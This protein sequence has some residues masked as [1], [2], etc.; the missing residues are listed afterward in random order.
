MSVH[1]GQPV[2][3]FGASLK[4]AEG[5]VVML[6]GRGGSAED[7]LSLASAMYRP[8][9]AYLAPQA[10]GNTW[11]PY[12]FLAPREENEPWLSSALAA[13]ASTVRMALDAGIG[14]EKIV[15]CGFS[16]GACLSAEF[17]A[18]EP[19]RYGGLIGFTG[20]LI[21][22]TLDADYPGELG[23]MPVFLG[24]GDPDPHVPWARVEKTGEVLRGMGAEVT[25]RRYPGRQHT[26]S[27]EEVDFGKRL[28]DGVFG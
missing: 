18:R 19:R 15:L 24:S 25:M 26:I 9:L 5:A 8:G 2:R 1:Q 7:I 21:G 14:V 10:A 6:H 20:G 12:S 27:G 28:V 11:Y 4:E 23:G 17:V 22:A 3:Q 16:Q 13:V